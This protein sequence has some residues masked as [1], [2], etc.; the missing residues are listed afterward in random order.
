MG[1]K[2]GEWAARSNFSAPGGKRH[3]SALAGS[4]S[5]YGKA[6]LDP[7]IRCMATAMHHNPVC[8]NSP[9]PQF[10]TLA[11]EF[12]RIIFPTGQFK[13]EKN[14]M[15]SLEIKSECDS[16]NL[17]PFVTKNCLPSAN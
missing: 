3:P 1:L 11:N 12:Y 13:T 17:R 16:E 4:V 6:G 15:V 10:K 8:F 7:F 5:S 14:A 9:N 2:R